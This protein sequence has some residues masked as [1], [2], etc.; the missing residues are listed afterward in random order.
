MAKKPTITTITSG[1]ASTTQLNNNFEALRDSLD[2]TVSRDGSSPNSMSA[3]LD[4]NSNDIL[5]AG[6]L[7]IEGTDIFSIVKKVTVSTSAPSGG[8]DQDIWF[9][10][11]S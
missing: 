10:V 3:D 6:G 5:N 8:S 4:M 7:Q 11:D 1:Y 2:N 9:K